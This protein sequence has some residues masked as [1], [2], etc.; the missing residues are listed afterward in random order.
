MKKRKAARR[1]GFWKN[2]LEEKGFYL[3]GCNVK[4]KIL[5]K[6]GSDTYT[7]IPRYEE[8]EFIKGIW[9]RGRIL[10][11]DEIYDMSVGGMPSCRY[12]EVYVYS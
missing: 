9:K 8:G 11:G 12:V 6:K 2:A 7:G 1:N 3:V 10:N 4:F 5:P